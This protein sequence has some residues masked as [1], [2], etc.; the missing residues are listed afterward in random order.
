MKNLYIL[1]I[2][3]TLLFFFSFGLFNPIYVLFLGYPIL[4]LYLFLTKRNYLFK[5]FL[6]GIIFAVIWTLIAKNYYGYGSNFGTFFGLN[7][8][9]LLAWPVGLLSLYIIFIEIEK[10]FNKPNK[11]LNFIIFSLAYIFFLLFAEY[12]AYHFFNI[13]NLATAS[14]P[15]I[16]FCNCLHAP[17]W[18]QWSYILF[19]PIYYLSS[20]ILD[21]KFRK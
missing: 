8:Y 6:L 12:I 1:D 21:K 11:I 19:G 15:G 4:L 7:I 9:P 16:Q 18:M 2:L 13:K 3:A 14:Y 20:E 17:T 5:N 10:K